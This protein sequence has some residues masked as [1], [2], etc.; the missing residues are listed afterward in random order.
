LV[1]A[2]LLDAIT[3]VTVGERIA[4]SK[5]DNIMIMLEMYFES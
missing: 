1:G 3:E 2:D 4:V 5:V